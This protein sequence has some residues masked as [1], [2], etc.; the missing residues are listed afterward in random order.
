GPDLGVRFP[1]GS[2]PARA[3][4]RDEATIMVLTTHADDDPA[5]LAAGEAA[6]VVLLAATALGLSTCPLSRVLETSRTR[7]DLARQVLRTA[8]HPQLLLR[9]GRAQDDAELPETP[10]RS[11]ADVLLH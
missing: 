11:P 3:A 1:G 8:D 5:R 9:V 4:V 2:L 6:G 10:R 7:A